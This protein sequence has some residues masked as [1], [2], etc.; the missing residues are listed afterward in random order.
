MSGAGDDVDNKTA[1][2]ISADRP[3]N[4]RGDDAFSR[5]PFAAGPLPPKGGPD[6]GVERR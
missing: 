1:W 3:I 6:Q 2:L 4:G 5:A